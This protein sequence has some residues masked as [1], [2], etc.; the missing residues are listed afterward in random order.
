MANR[1]STIERALLASGRFKASS[2]NVAY[3]ANG[4]KAPLD[5][6]P[7][8]RLVAQRWAV[9]AVK[10]ATPFTCMSCGGAVSRIMNAQDVYGRL[11]VVLSHSHARGNAVGLVSVLPDGFALMRC[12]DNACAVV[13]S[14]HIDNL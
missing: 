7:R 13:Y 4:S 2:V 8:G 14:T 11:S 6:E 12:D 5:M 1:N 10:A 3:Y 9:G